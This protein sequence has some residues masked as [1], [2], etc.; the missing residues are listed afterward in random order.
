MSIASRIRLISLIVSDIFSFVSF[1]EEILF[2]ILSNP[3]VILLN[4]VLACSPSSCI[5]TPPSFFIS[6]KL[7]LKS[8]SSKLCFIPIIAPVSPAAPAINAV[9]GFNAPINDNAPN[10]TPAPAVISAKEPDVNLPC[11]AI[12]LKALLISVASVNIPAPPMLNFNV[13]ESPANA[14]FIF[15]DIFPTSVLLISCALFLAPFVVDFLIQFHIAEPTFPAFS[16]PNLAITAFDISLCIAFDNCDNTVFASCILA[17]FLIVTAPITIA[18]V[19]ISR[20]PINSAIRFA[21]V[22]HL[23]LVKAVNTILNKPLTHLLIAFARDFASKFSKNPLMPLA[24]LSPRLLQSNA[25][26]NDKA[27]YMAVF[28]ELAIVLPTA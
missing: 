21:I 14:E 9:N 16:V 17:I 13:F 10:A 24:I 2:F 20:L 15:V 12:V 1:I 3:C 19:L 28:N 22:P 23:I 7:A 8:A 6:S 26:P 27:V 18:M 5:V 11:S 25:S 4:A